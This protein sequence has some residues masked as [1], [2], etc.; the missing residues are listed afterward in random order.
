M[1]Q[2]FFVDMTMPDTLSDFW[3]TSITFLMET[4]G[5]NQ[6]NSQEFFSFSII[7]TND[8]VLEIMSIA[9]IHLLRVI[10][11]DFQE[12]LAMAQ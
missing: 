8:A 4:T 10:M 9:L 11:G 12:E 3:F 1:E 2:S 6:L 5:E 7:G